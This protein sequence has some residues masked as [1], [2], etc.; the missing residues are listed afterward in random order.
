MPENNVMNEC[1]WYVASVMTSNMA[2]DICT[3]HLTS[4]SVGHAITDDL[5]SLLGTAAYLCLC[6]RSN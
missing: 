5:H 4:L 2:A 6:M 1:I 3:L